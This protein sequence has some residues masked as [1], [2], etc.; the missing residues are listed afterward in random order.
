MMHGAAAG[1]MAPITLSGSLSAS[2]STVQIT[3][4]T[5]T[6]TVPSPNSGNIRFEAVFNEGA[7]AV[8]YSKNGAAFVALTSNDVVNFA[9]AETLQMRATGLGVDQGGG[10]RLVDVSSGRT[11]QNVSL[12]R[13]S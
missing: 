12:D 4:T 11:I 8:Q 3:G 1:G 6:V 5:R 2:G 9:N 10:A 7:G 13:T